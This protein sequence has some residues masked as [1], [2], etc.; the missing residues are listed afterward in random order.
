MTSSGYYNHMNFE[1][2]NWI[3]SMLLKIYYFLLF[4]LLFSVD[5]SETVLDSHTRFSCYITPCL[6]VSKMTCLGRWLCSLI[7]CTVAASLYL[8]SGS[9]Y[10]VHPLPPPG[11]SAFLLFFSHFVLLFGAFPFNELSESHLN[12][13][14][15]AKLSELLSSI[16]GI[17]NL[18]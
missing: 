17:W 9:F 4:P 13:G 5:D 3:C 7:S 14:T 6:E 8:I 16:C 15:F 12:R 18:P 10:L 2:L 1:S 11:R